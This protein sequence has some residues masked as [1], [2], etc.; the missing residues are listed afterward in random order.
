MSR[1]IEAFFFFVLPHG[2]SVPSFFFLSRPLHRTRLPRATAFQSK[3]PPSTLFAQL[4]PKEMVRV[5][6]KKKKK[7]S[8]KRSETPETKEDRSDSDSTEEEK[9]LSSS[10]P[11]ASPI[12]PPSADMDHMV[13]PLFQPRYDFSLPS[14]CFSSSS[15][16][17]GSRA[18]LIWFDCSADRCFVFPSFLLSLFQ[19]SSLH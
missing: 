17:S 9:E 6:K 11:L 13:T 19:C 1:G 8:P 10:A 3:A 2:F 5:R 4:N 15:Q 18:E 14:S 7:A 12:I 16:F